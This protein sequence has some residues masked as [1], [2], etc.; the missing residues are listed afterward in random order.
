[1]MGL[2]DKLLRRAA[3]TEAIDK[4]PCPHTVLVPRWDSVKDMGDS[5]QVTRYRCDGCGTEFSKE[6]G[7]QLMATERERLRRLTE[8]QEEEYKR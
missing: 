3:K 5:E 2:L 8:A 7:V 4:P 6:E 1:M